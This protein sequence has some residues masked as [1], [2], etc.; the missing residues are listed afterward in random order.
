MSRVKRVTADGDVEASIT[1]QL[2]S[3]TVTAGVDAASVVIKEAGAS[4]TAF[5]TVKAPIETTVQWRA[6]DPNG[7][8]IN[9]PYADVSGTSPIADIEYS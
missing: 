9:K 3:V 7:V 4:G 5:I 2:H 6:G 8:Q 1:V